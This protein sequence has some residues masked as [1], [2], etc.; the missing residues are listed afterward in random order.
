[1]HNKHTQGIFF[2]FNVCN[3]SKKK[4]ILGK[5]QKVVLEI[6]TLTK[7]K[8]ALDGLISRLDMVKEI[9]SEPDDT[10]IGSLKTEK[11]REQRVKKGK[12]YPRTMGQLQK[13]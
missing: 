5:N 8:T 2:I 10:L 3:I 1:M 4:E 12:E 6:K 9:I 11:Q 7:M 13:V